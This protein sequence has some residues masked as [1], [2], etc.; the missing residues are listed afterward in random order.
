MKVLQHLNELSFF[1][2]KV[3]NWFRFW[4]QQQRGFLFQKRD[5]QRGSKLKNEYGSFSKLKKK[6]VNMD[7]LVDTRYH[8]YQKIR[9]VFMKNYYY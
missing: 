1:Y 6:N 9:S 4:N 3:K 5:T 2:V 7:S 8:V